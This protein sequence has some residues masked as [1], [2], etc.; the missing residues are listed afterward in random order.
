M[1][2]SRFTFSL[3]YQPGT[4]EVSPGPVGPT[5]TH[6]PLMTPGTV[7]AIELAPWLMPTSELLIN[8]EPAETR[9]ALIEDG[10]VTELHIERSGERSIVGNVYSGKVS[11]V[12]R[13]MQAA[14]VDIGLSRHAFLQ[15]SDSVRPEDL[16]ALAATEAHDEVAHT[17]LRVSKETPIGKVLRPGQPVV[18]QVSRAPVGKKGA[19]VT[20]HVSLA[21]RY[22]VHLPTLDQIGVSRRIED[23]EERKRLRAAVE[24][25]RSG[26]GFIVRTAAEGVSREVLIQDLNYLTRLWNMILE[27]W[28][29]SEP[30]ALLHADL[31]LPLRAARDLMGS[32]TD[33]LMIDD[34]ETFERIRTFA[35]DSMPENTAKIALYQGDEPIFDARGI[36]NEIHRALARVIP[37]PSGGSLVFDHAEA[38]TA[39]DVNTGRFSGGKDLEETITRTNLEAV[40]E[41]AYQLRLRNIGGLI[42]VDFIDMDQPANRE[43]VN[44]ALQ[45]ALKDDRVQTTAIRISE[46][47]LV[48]MTRKGTNQGLA[49]QLF[50]PCFYCD[51]T[52]HLKSKT[53]I[54]CEV[55]RVVR[56][57]SLEIR[58]PRVSIEC[59]PDVA[60]LLERD[61]RTTLAEIGARYG[62]EIEVEARSD[63]HLERFDIKGGRRHGTTQETP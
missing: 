19:R 34:Q 15:V 23:E 61:H 42:V 39:I 5:G 10:V 11:R 40:K 31:D 33:R 18:V 49:R 59:H 22:L 27:H 28:A 36:E 14:F 6:H 48:E 24:E 9:V 29:E 21:G 8:V 37:L 7:C 35:S 20:S 17:S 38:L 3:S 16:D 56:R 32:Q 41:L 25:V 57:R 2:Q 44:Q 55:L 54:C 50:E 4:P 47:G 12:M 26:G 45:E 58:A 30:P 1:C 63:F 53:T 62:K 46:L 13:G 43:K 51:G 52:G 60:S